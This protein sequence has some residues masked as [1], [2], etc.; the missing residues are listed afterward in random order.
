MAAELHAPDLCDA[1]PQSHL[2]PAKLLDSLGQRNEMLRV[3]FSQMVDRLEDLKSLSEDFSMIVE[4]IEAIAEE[5]PHAK[6][7]VM[8]T[9]ALL[10]REIEANQN[11]RREVDALTSELSATSGE[12]TSYTTRARKLEAECHEMTGTVDEQR[13]LLREQAQLLDNIERQLAVEAEQHSSVAAELALQRAEREATE[14][15]LQRAQSELQRE[16]E[17]HSIFERECRRLH[18]LVGEQSERI[19][20]LEARAN[21][22]AEQRE[23]QKGVFAALEVRLQE[24]ELACQK[25]E[26]EHES[27]VGQL[28]A[29]RTSL[30]L[31]VDAAA[32]RLA[33][34]EHILANLRSQFR[35]KDEALRITERSLKDALLERIAADRRLEAMRNELVHQ[36]AQVSEIHRLRQEAD[37]RNEMLTKTLAAKDV[38]LENSLAKAVSLGDRLETLTRRNENDRVKQ[39]AATRRLIEE[40]ESERAERTL[41]QGALEIAR[42]NRVALQ[43]QNEILKRSVRAMQTQGELVIPEQNLA[44]DTGQTTNVSF[45][46]RPDSRPE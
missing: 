32:A 45:L 15:S 17:Q 27:I 16:S 44:P 14:Q 7:R 11:L 6:A 5:L 34:T 40:L 3:R 26:E 10:S 46:A 12:L 18:Q 24:A 2:R 37:E 23:R 29:E 30:T 36:S 33:S 39:E 41:A 21:E 42:E 28:T 9:E 13:A 4:P 35:D 1:D 22:L 31:K 38:A 8:E 43:R 19:V 25:A 20:G